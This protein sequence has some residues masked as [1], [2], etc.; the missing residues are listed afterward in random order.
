MNPTTTSGQQRSTKFLCVYSVY[1]PSIRIAAA[2]RAWCDRSCTHREWCAASRVR[3][4]AGAYPGACACAYAGACACACACVRLCVRE[5]VRAHQAYSVPHV[6][7]ANSFRFSARDCACGRLCVREIVRAGDCAGA[8]G[9]QRPPREQ[10]EQLQ[11]Q[12]GGLPGLQVQHL[13]T[14]SVSRSVS[15]QPQR[16]PQRQP[17]AVSRQPSATRSV[18]SAT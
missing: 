8:P 17:A 15:R 10:R 14:R 13:R 16:Q 7:N 12:C 6:S 18:H 9:V 3:V 2:E 1:K 5:P 11:V 4:R